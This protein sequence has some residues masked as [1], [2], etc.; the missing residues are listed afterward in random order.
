M[1]TTH[2]LS[3]TKIRGLFSQSWNRILIRNDFDVLLGSE[4]KVSRI[5]FNQNR[6]AVKVL[7]VPQSPSELNPIR[8]V[9]VASPTLHSP[10]LKRNGF[11]HQKL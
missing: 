8:E 9:N 5:T 3:P 6:R 11:C 2:Y 7:V 1:T 10:S 4:K